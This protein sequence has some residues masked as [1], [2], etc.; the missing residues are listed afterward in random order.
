MFCHIPIRSIAFSIHR[1]RK[2][3][4]RLSPT[5]NLLPAWPGHVRIWKIR[6]QLPPI[7]Y[8]TG[9]SGKSSV[10]IYI[11]L[12]YRASLNFDIRPPDNIMRL[13]RLVLFTQPFGT[14]G[15]SMYV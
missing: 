15:K 10:P 2:T 1:T 6:N 11:R 14:K 13:G 7:L 5:S 3:N 4:T 12:I 8:N 9:K